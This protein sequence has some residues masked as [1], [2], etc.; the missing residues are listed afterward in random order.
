MHISIRNMSSV[1]LIVVFVMI[2][3]PASSQYSRFN[4]DKKNID[5]FNIFVNVA[6]TLAYRY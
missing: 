2:S 1:I 6:F 3:A 5:G 4:E